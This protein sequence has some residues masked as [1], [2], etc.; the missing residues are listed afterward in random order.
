MTFKL[1]EIRKIMISPSFD[2]LNSVANYKKELIEKRNQINLIIENVEKTIAHKKGEI[3]MSNK[4]K[5]EG[6]K[7]EL[8]DKNEEKYGK[9][10]CKNYMD[11]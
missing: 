1:E 2:I 9:E 7:K 6:F 8:I 11:D 4:E 3:Y 5:F 10:I